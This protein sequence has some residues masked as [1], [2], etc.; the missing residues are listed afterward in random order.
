MVKR[1]QLSHIIQ[2]CFK[3]KV[4]LL[5]G[6][7]QVGKTTLLEELIKKIDQPSNWLNAD[8]ADIFEAF[9]KAKTSS[10]LIQLIGS[11]KK[12]VV[13]DEAQQIPDIGKKLKLIYDSKADVQV[14]ATGSS[15]F[16]LQNRT[17]EPL[18]GRKK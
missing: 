18:T 17:A 12:L 1:E 8:E 14:I 5:L 16:D 4:I 7:R 3:G 13:I 2:D 15:A 10:Q 9:T 6:A 11:N